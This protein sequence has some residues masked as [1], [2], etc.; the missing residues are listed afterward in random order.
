MYAFQHDRYIFL[1][2]ILYTETE[3]DFSFESINIKIDTT[4]DPNYGQL[5]FHWLSINLTDFPFLI[6]ASRY[7]II[8]YIWYQQNILLD[9]TYMVFST[10]I[11]GFNQILQS[12]STVKRTQFQFEISYG[13][14]TISLPGDFQDIKTT[15]VKEN[16]KF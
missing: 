7:K 6:N 13:R 3:T 15:F 9:S 5:G 12:S 8:Y 4:Q 14:G 1:Q 16:Y 10:K 11:D 2:Y